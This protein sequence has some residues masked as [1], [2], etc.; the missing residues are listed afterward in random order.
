MTGGRSATSRLV[1]G[2]GKKKGVRM[3]V[4]YEGVGEG[5]GSKVLGVVGVRGAVVLG[6]PLLG[7]M[8]RRRSYCAPVGTCV[9][10]FGGE[11]VETVLPRRRSTVGRRNRIL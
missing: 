11:F 9:L 10:L 7:L 6:V 8:R 2:E 1:E 3:S 5:G 4:E